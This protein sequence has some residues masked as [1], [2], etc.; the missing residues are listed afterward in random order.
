MAESIITNYDMPEPRLA[1]LIRVGIDH[2]TDPDLV[3]RLLIEE[4]KRAVG[5]VPGLLAEP[6]PPARLIPGFG[7]F[8]LDFTLACQVRSFTEQ[9]A[10][11][12]E[13]RK[14][15]LKRLAAEGV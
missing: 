3:E 7:D 4:A 14:R 2:S 10:V 12:H 6:A 15:I 1:L 5:E 8:S 13:L 9:F 11:Q